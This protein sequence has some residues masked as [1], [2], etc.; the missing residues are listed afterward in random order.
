V[1]RMVFRIKRFACLFFA[2]I[3]MLYTIS[4]PIPFL[5]IGGAIAAGSGGAW[6]YYIFD[7]E[8]TTN[9]IVADFSTGS[10]D[11]VIDASSQ[12]FVFLDIEEKI[13][14]HS[15]HNLESLD[16]TR[17]FDIEITSFDCLPPFSPSAYKISGP[18]IDKINTM[19]T[20]TPGQFMFKLQ[21]GSGGAGSRVYN[22]PGAMS[23]TFG[24]TD[25]ETRL[26]ECDYGLTGI[27]IQ[28]TQP[29]LNYI[30]QNSQSSEGATQDVA[31][32]LSGTPSA[33]AG[34]P[35][36]AVSIEKKW[37]GLDFSSS[38]EPGITIEDIKNG[39]TFSYSGYSLDLPK[40]HKGNIIYLDVSDVLV[41]IPN[42]DAQATVSFKIEIKDA[43][44]NV[45]KTGSGTITMTGTELYDAL[46][47]LPGGAT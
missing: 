39:L 46:E 43:G 33:A 41:Y 20:F 14:V 4:A 7:K 9:S 13:E 22:L 8:Y 18:L 24:P 34:I 32:I 29:V 16:T 28:F 3:L 44:G 2:L 31:D 37:L 47:A 38:I 27:T 1:K 15:R 17:L 21:H 45:K 42:T 5:L 35:P 26:V 23:I 11:G 12:R 40:K 19:N 36:G 25:A 30:I 10:S 6:L